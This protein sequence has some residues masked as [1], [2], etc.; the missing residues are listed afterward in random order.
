[1]VNAFNFQSMWCVE[2]PFTHL[3]NEVL[4]DFVTK[5]QDKYVFIVLIHNFLCSWML[6]VGY[7]TNVMVINFIDSSLESIHVIIEIFELFEE[8]NIT[9]VAME[10]QVKVLSLTCLVC[11]TKLLFMS[12]TNGQI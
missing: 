6:H 3:V 2:F 7:E 12:K 9:N 11:L 1:M 4:L 5:T 10:K 8:Q